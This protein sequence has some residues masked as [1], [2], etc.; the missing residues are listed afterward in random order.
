[1]LGGV[2]HLGKDVLTMARADTLDY[3]HVDWYNWPVEQIKGGLEKN[4]K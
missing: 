3:F 4:E 1:M 2:S